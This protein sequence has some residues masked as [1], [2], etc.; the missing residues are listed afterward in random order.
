MAAIGLRLAVAPA[1]LFVI[2]LPILQLPP[3]YLFMAA[4]P[5]GLNGLL[6]ANAFGLDRRT[7]AG[8]IAW[9]TGLVLAGAGIGTLVT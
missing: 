4:M 8:A 6:V 9:S 5:C 7:S 2:A 3:V 1:L